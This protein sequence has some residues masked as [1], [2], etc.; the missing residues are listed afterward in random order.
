MTLAE[1]LTIAALLIGP[2]A[3]VQVQKWL[4]AYREAR[5][6]RL[7]I[8]KTLM[9]TRASNLAAEHV[10]ALNMIDL[11]FHGKTFQRV[12]RA[13]KIYL[14]HLTSFPKD[15]E[16]QQEIWE[17]RRID[18]LVELLMSMGESLGYSFDA[19]QIKKSIYAP[20]GHSR[21]ENEQI[22]VRRGLARVLWGAQP[23]KMEVTSIPVNPEAVEVQKMLIDA[24]RKQATREAVH[25]TIA[26]AVPAKDPK[27]GG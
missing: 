22:M 9:A 25:K 27:Q 10:Q 24:A 4:E 23:L 20:E 5:G 6:R 7:W 11:E 18:F 17:S 8:F 21:I 2:V 14:D 15:N 26:E 16:K 1:G 13:W 12:T 3:A 19:V